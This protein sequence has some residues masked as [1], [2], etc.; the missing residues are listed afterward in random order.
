MALYRAGRQADALEAFQRL[1]H[2]PDEHLGVEP[3]AEMRDLYQ[4]MLNQD[5]VLD[6]RSPASSGDMAL[7][8][9]VPIVV[10]QL[11]A[12]IGDFT[13]RDEQIRFLHNAISARSGRAGQVPVAVITGGGGLGKT[14]LAIAAAHQ[15][16]DSFPD[17]SLFV[18][19]HGMD[20]APRDPAEVLR[21]WLLGLVSGSDI[22]LAAAAALAGLPLNDAEAALDVLLDSHLANSAGPGRYRLHD[23]LRDFAR[24]L[25]MPVAGKC[26]EG[27]A[28]LAALT[29][30]ANWYCHA[31]SAA[32]D[33]LVTQRSSWGLARVP[34]L[35]FRPARLGTRLAARVVSDAEQPLV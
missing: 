4:R 20:A 26:S 3:S 5:P 34:G 14:S 21:Q 28:A 1:R 29:P 8:E 11:P 32:A 9:P 25:V 22:S 6:R 27:G 18:D 31:A 7:A 12:L 15:V 2:L 16:S 17:G 35:P 24:E 23:L 13:G 19:L 30:L 10:A 33:Q